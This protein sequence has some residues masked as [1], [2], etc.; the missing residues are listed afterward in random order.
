MKIKHILIAVGLV[1]I[2]LISLLWKSFDETNDAPAIAQPFDNGNASDT[3]DRPLGREPE[4]AI[5]ESVWEQNRYPEQLQIADIDMPLHFT[6]LVDDEIKQVIIADMHLIFG[7]ATGHSFY[8][9]LPQSSEN[10][11]EN[12]VVTKGRR[13]QFDGPRIFHPDEYRNAF[14]AVATINNQEHILVPDALVTAYRDALSRR[15]AYPEEYRK[16][17]EF[18]SMMGE[19]WAG[20]AKENDL[21]PTMNELFH[22]DP[23]SKWAK[24]KFKNEGSK[25]PKAFLAANAMGA[26]ASWRMPSLLEIKQ[27]PTGH[28]AELSSE[29]PTFL[30]PYYYFDTAGKLYRGGTLIY[31]DANWKILVSDIN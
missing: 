13:L 17:E 9:P 1:T 20:T 6:E 31:V 4:P 2:G 28:F 24:Q 3:Q 26:G 12:E 7:H 10:A 27:D 14:G 25:G 29:T 23:A 22:P 11:R 21:P 19:V 18:V 15:L 8:T 30:S 16:L 5:F